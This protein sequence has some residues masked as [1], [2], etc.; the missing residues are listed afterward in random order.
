ML[1]KNYVIQ[2]KNYTIQVKN[3]CIRARNYV[4]QSKNYVIQVK[5]YVIQVE[6]YAIQEKES[7]NLSK[8]EKWFINERAYYNSGY[9]QLL[10]IYKVV[11]LFTLTSYIASGK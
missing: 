7:P 4:I 11:Y 3:Y 6:K 9:I 1:V 10:G 5:K 8:I 2:A